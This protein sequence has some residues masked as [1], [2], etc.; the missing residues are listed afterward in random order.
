MT[1]NL[2]KSIEEEEC[3]PHTSVL[4]PAFKAGVKSIVKPI[5]NAAK[6]ATQDP[7]RLRRFANKVATSAANFA[8][9]DV[10]E[11]APGNSAGAGG[12]DMNVTGGSTRL[13]KTPDPMKRVQQYDP[14]S[15]KKGKKKLLLTKF[16]HHAYGK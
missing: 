9:N 13:K 4:H 15:N 7:N 12:V 1:R 10:K 11:D 6:K 14:A 3:P 8:E 5:A 2:K 16:K